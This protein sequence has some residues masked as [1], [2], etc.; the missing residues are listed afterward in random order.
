M[1]GDRGGPTLSGWANHV[2]SRWLLWEQLGSSGL[3][4]GAQVG[5]SFPATPGWVL[6]PASWL[7]SLSPISL[8]I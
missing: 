7:I 1:K 8:L 3:L 2:S 4:G 5:I 6:L